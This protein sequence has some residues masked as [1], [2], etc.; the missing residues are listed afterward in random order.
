[1]QKQLHGDT[2]WY[3]V[4]AGYWCFWHDSYPLLG[5]SF[6]QT[7]LWSFQRSHHW[8]PLKPVDSYGINNMDSYGFIGV[9]LRDSTG[10]LAV[11][12]CPCSLG[13]DRQFRGVGYPHADKASCLCWFSILLTPT[14]T[15]IMNHYGILWVWV[16]PTWNSMK[17]DWWT[18]YDSANICKLQKKSCP[19]LKGCHGSHVVNCC[20]TTNSTEMLGGAGRLWSTS[21]NSCRN[22]TATRSCIGFGKNIGYIGYIIIVSWA[23]FC[24]EVS[25]EWTKRI[26]GWKCCP[27]KVGHGLSCEHRQQS[28][29]QWN[30]I[31]KGLEGC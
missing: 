20:F 8:V 21:Q 4:A 30:V 7:L 28:L 18:Y 1:M 5:S 14:I 19:C 31:L 9:I 12:I 11:S 24:G 23:Q 10:S 29:D 22:P 26:S 2:R 3:T 25:A 17:L 13:I 6:V 27:G 15:I 16:I